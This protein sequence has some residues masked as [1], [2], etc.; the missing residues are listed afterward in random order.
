MDLGDCDL[1]KSILMIRDLISTLGPKVPFQARSP[2]TTSCSLEEWEH[3][4]S[5]MTVTLEQ[6]SVEAHPSH[7][8]CCSF[9]TLAGF[10]LGSKL[11]LSVPTADSHAKFCPQSCL[12]RPTNVACL[13]VQSQGPLSAYGC[14]QWGSSQRPLGF[15]THL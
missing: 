9:L 10:E 1:L 11:P 6:R 14:H 5:P 3:S 7:S 8:A 4:S 2:S 12:W 15:L 13:P